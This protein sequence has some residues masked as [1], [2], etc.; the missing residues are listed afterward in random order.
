MGDCIA[1]DMTELSVDALLELLTTLAAGVGAL[2]L[3]AV[4][5]LAEQAGLQN[6]ALGHVPLGIWEAGMGA[7][8]L[9]VGVYL[10][11]YEQFWRRIQ[12]RFFA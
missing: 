5:M 1:G 11:G 8:L 10:L 6:L 2:V 7:V 12:L 9:F 3:T 4:G